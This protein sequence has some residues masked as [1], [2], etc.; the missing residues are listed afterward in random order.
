MNKKQLKKANELRD[1]TFPCPKCNEI[2][3]TRMAW[4]DHIKDMHPEVENLRIGGEVI[5]LKE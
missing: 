1:L 4:I 5:K 2:V 3:K